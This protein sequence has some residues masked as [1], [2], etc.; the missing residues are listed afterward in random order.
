MPA[1]AACDW[2]CFQGG[3]TLIALPSAPARRSFFAAGGSAAV[4]ATPAGNSGV[5]TVIVPRIR[6]KF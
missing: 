2:A 6:T 4:T 3:L 1:A 5:V